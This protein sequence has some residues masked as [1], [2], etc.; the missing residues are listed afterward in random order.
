MTPSPA[1]RTA[2]RVKK[3][4]KEQLLAFF[5]RKIAPNAPEAR[6]LATHVFAKA[7]APPTLVTD[8]LPEELYPVPREREPPRTQGAGRGGRGLVESV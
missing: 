7:A 1:H 2:A 5:D 6:R 3:V 4:T 8:P